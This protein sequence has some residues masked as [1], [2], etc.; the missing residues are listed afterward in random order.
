MQNTSNYSNVIYTNKAVNDETIAAII[1]NEENTVTNGCNQYIRNLEQKNLLVI[2][3]NS[4]IEEVCSR[5]K[6]TFNEIMDEFRSMGF[7]YDVYNLEEGRQFGFLNDKRYGPKKYTIINC[8]IDGY[9][10][11]IRYYAFCMIRHFYYYEDYIVKYLEFANSDM[12]ESTKIKLHSFLSGAYNVGNTFIFSGILKNTTYK[13]LFT[14]YNK[15]KNNGNQ[16]L[17]AVTISGTVKKSNKITLEEF[18]N[19]FKIYDDLDE[20]LGNCLYFNSKIEQLDKYLVDVKKLDPY[21][22][23][24]SGGSTP[25]FAYNIK[26]LKLPYIES[27]NNRFYVYLYTASNQCYIKSSNKD[28][29]HSLSRFNLDK[30]TKYINTML[31]SKKKDITVSI[32][33]RHPSHKVFRNTLISKFKTLIRLGSTTPSTVK[34]DIEL[35]KI[36]AIQNS[37]NKLLMKQCFTRA[38][39][40][41]PNWYTIAG[42]LALRNGTETGVALD[43]L[44]FPIVAKHILG[45][46]GTGNYKID[47]VNDL[48]AFTN[49]RRAEL[50]S[51]IFEEFVNYAK[52]YRIHVS[53]E[54]TFLM[55]RKLRRKDTPDNQKWFFNNENCNW[56][57][58]DNEL[59][60]VPTSIKAMQS[61]CLKALNS[62]GLDFGACDIRTMSNTNK[63]GH[64]R[65]NVEFSI[66]EINSAPSMA[67]RTSE[68]YIEEFMKLI[69]KRSVA[70]V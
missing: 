1:A 50:T 59:F 13:E 46:R 38:G 63:D 37:S 16:E 20:I 70:L 5:S 9:S 58:V 69:Q 49:R 23:I 17:G 14:L 45:S 51:F 43:T 56:V 33:S 8:P 25:I 19:S 24:S 40:K 47:N 65:D 52:E 53:T 60:D 42:N 26:D 4:Y 10:N 68:A 32:R 34:W 39:V 15:Q 22:R 30:Y 21:F 2:I 6:K 41:T 35:N 29:V 55:W 7:K 18:Y 44:Q 62:V 67:E 27:E 64:R 12:D 28:H 3:P 11:H 48:V 36:P 54:G 31:L 61:E 66:I 57:G